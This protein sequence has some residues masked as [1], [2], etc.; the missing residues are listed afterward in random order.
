[1]DRCTT[2]RRPVAI[3]LG[4]VLGMTTLT[5]AAAFVTTST[6]APR[7]SPVHR[8][9]EIALNIAGE[10]A[11]TAPPKLLVGERDFETFVGR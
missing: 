4:L 3:V 8:A 11:A 5:S 1:M 6:G 9:E 10:E 7:R 2:A